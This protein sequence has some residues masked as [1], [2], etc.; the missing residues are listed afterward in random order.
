M[1]TPKGGFFLFI[2][3][4]ITIVVSISTAVNFWEGLDAFLIMGLG[5]VLSDTADGSTRLDDNIGKAFA[6]MLVVLALACAGSGNWWLLLH[7][8][9]PAVLGGA[10]GVMSNRLA[11]SFQGDQQSG[12]STPLAKIP[13]E[14]DPSP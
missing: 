2:G 11:I 14:G 9:L 7:Y 3:M 4:V 1:A 5:N 12:D 8:G 6:P 13:I 10:W